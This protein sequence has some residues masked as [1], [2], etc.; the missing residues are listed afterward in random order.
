MRCSGRREKDVS[1]I[2][3]KLLFVRSAPVK[4]DNAV[5]RESNRCCKCQRA[6]VVARGRNLALS[7]ALLSAGQRLRQLTPGSW[8]KSQHLQ[9]LYLS[10]LIHSMAMIHPNLRGFVYQ[11][12]TV[13]AGPRCEAYV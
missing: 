13:L 7:V 2:L 12:I 10:R 4:L 1:V 6:A 11:K 8:G 9:S 5:P 3:C